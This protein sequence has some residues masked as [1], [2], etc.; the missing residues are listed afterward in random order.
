MGRY[1][2]LFNLLSHDCQIRIHAINL[3]GHGI[4]TPQRGHAGGKEILCH[5]VRNLLLLDAAS[6]LPKFLVKRFPLKFPSSTDG[7]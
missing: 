7:T 1:E 4:G 3:P 5:A 6:N 2:R